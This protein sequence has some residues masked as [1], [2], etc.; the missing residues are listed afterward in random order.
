MFLQ[1]KETVFSVWANIV[2]TWIL[3]FIVSQPYYI[4]DFA[5]FQKREKLKKRVFHCHLKGFGFS[6]LFC[7]LP[8]GMQILKREN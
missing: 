8:Y 3:H 4:A 1:F 6:E 5:E 7:F 2:L